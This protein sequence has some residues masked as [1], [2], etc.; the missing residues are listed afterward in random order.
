[1]FNWYTLA[2]KHPSPHSIALWFPVIH[3]GVGIY[4]AYAT[5]AGLINCTVVSISSDQ[6]VVNHGPLPW[7][8]NKSV[9]A[10]TIRQL[11][12]DE[13]T[14]SGRGGARSG[15]RL[16]TVTADGRKEV[17]VSAGIARDEALYLEQIAEQRLGIKA[18][19]VIGELS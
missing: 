7:K 16:N 15:F 10:A 9:D 5:L 3:V 4:L 13:V 8:G 1:M 11:F 19:P 18:E 17:L 14:R 2:L 6:I 12:C